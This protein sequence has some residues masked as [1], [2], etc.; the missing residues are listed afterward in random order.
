MQE[1]F[2]VN[3][4]DNG[5]ALASALG[6]IREQL[7]AMKLKP[8]ES[9][10]AELMCEETLTLLMSHADFSGLSYFRVS[11]RKIFGDVIIDLRVPGHEFEFSGAVQNIECVVPRCSV[12]TCNEVFCA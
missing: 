6:F 10:H 2:T 7:G 3:D 5:E 4:S 1:K 9:S 11:V 8:K 12:R